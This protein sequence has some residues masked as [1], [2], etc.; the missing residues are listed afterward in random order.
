MENLHDWALQK[1]DEALKKGVD[2]GAA[3]YECFI[4]REHSPEELAKDKAFRELYN[5]VSTYWSA[6]A[7]GKKGGQFDIYSENKDD[8]LQE[9]IQD[10]SQTIFDVT[11]GWI[12]FPED[13]VEIVDQSD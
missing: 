3:E 2:Y 10:L 11:D 5:A 12:R 7:Y 1:Y 4:G 8:I 6:I 13:K 9:V